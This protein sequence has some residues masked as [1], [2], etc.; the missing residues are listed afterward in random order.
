MCCSPDTAIEG[1]AKRGELV[2]DAGFRED[3]CGAR[4]GSPTQVVAALL[5]VALTILPLKASN[6]SG[7]TECL[8]RKI[9]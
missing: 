1:G 6:I 3:A 4:D 7:A 5:N 9:A 2:R 8:C